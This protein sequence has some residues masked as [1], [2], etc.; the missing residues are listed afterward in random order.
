M[1]GATVA[2]LA[3]LLAGRAGA[4]CACFG[5]KGRVGTAS[6]GRAAA[7]AAALALAPLLP[8][9][10]PTT[11]G[12][13]AIGLAVTALGLVALAI[14]VLALARE[15]GMLRLAVPQ[16]GA[17]EIAHEGPEV[18]ARSA[19]ARRLRA[20]T[21]PRPPRPG[22][23]HLRGLRA[24]PRAAARGRGLRRAPERGRCARSTR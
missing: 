17:L 6:A 12:W 1:A 22:G 5:S 19:L 11:E 8:R 15:L 7:L 4:P 23:L 9:T 10:E 16:G 14:V 13:L 21:H 20:G 24:V 3:A 2:Q 18:G